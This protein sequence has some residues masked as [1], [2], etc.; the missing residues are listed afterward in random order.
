MYTPLTSMR[1]L[2]RPDVSVVC[3]TNM[4]H[5]LTLLTRV[6]K[7]RNPLITLPPTSSPIW[8]NAGK[9]ETTEGLMLTLNAA[10][11]DPFFMRIR[12]GNNDAPKLN[13]STA[14]W[15]ISIANMSVAGLLSFPRV[16]LRDI[17]MMQDA[18]DTLATDADF[19]PPDVTE[20]TW[21]DIMAKDPIREPFAQ[22]ALTMAYE[23][24]VRSNVFDKL[25][26]PESTSPEK[27]QYT[28]I[29][30][31]LLLTTMLRTLSVQTSLLRL[32]PMLRYLRMEQSQ[33]RLQEELLPAT[34][35]YWN[36]LIDRI[37]GMPVH[38]WIALAEGTSVPAGRMTPWGNS[39][40]SIL[41]DRAYL[42]SPW[43]GTRDPPA[44]ERAAFAA[45]MNKRLDAAGLLEKMSGVLKSVRTLMDD[46][47]EG[48]R[49]TKVAALLGFV[50]T[51]APVPI[52]LYGADFKP[53][54]TDGLNATESMTDII[55][56]TFQPHFP[57]LAP[58][59]SPWVGEDQFVLY[60][61]GDRMNGSGTVW[62]DFTAS[63]SVA[64][65]DIVMDNNFL[66]NRFSPKMFKYKDD[67]YKGD[68]NAVTFPATVEGVATVLGRSQTDLISS[69]AADEVQWRDIFLVERSRDN[70]L[71]LKPVRPDGILFYSDRTQMPWLTDIQLPRR[72]VPSVMW[73][74]RRG[75][76]DTAMPTMAKFERNTEV[77]TATIPMA[78]AVD[79]LQQQAISAQ[80]A[81]VRKG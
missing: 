44:A 54:H 15:L 76:A 25:T 21:H 80:L 2:L 1:Q 63:I 43:D 45:E 47:A 9:N 46:L 74:M 14:P 39:T 62:S 66:A 28:L 50:T 77:P 70:V 11:V 7:A 75:R 19:N 16:N 3:D 69:V 38:P 24:I 73:A 52:P 35:E 78:A 41:L 13:E 57:V 17:P 67:S 32:R 18:L 33:V 72:G 55:A 20:S 71:G 27:S 34:L 81:G 65:E 36:A 31:G 60:T 53:F 49:F 42:S 4:A 22:L 30:R 79:R 26:G 8:Q 10:A 51:G 56:K 23:H 6:L 58:G 61:G 5:V 29:E 37:L 40:P 48:E 68:L 64:P 59:Y 12:S